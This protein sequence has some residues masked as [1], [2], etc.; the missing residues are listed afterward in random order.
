[1]LMDAR[2]KLA[3]HSSGENILTGE[4]KEQ[5]QNKVDLFQRKIESMEIEL[6]EWVRLRRMCV[7]N[8]CSTICSTIAPQLYFVATHY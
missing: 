5:F 6:E 4:Q 8:T 7:S 3:D 2:K 1:M